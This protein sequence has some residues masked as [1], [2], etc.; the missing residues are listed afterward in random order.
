MPGVFDDDA[1]FDLLA[2]TVH[3]LDAERGT[4]G[5]HAFYLSI[6]PAFFSTVC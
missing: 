1:A 3:E 4:G 2:K 6:P 5:N